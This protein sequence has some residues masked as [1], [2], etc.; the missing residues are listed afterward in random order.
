MSSETM[1]RTGSAPVR[2]GPGGRM[3]LIGW[4]LLAGLAGAIGSIASMNS[5]EFYSALARPSWAPPGWLFGP[6]WSALY[7]LMG[8]G[9]WAVWRERPT[10]SRATA[11]RRRGLTLFVV[12]L[13]LNALWTWI[14][15]AWRQGALAF[16]EIVLLW[17]VIAL[18]IVEFA[19]VRRGAAWCLA[20]YLLWVT[21]ATALTWSI[22]RANPGQL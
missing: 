12:Q 8:I 13:V 20:P 2:R 19:R 9:A 17:V 18:T 10:T 3:A 16:A 6:V 22:W 21:Y 11:S 1:N 4:V 15:F 5:R 14:F 7:V